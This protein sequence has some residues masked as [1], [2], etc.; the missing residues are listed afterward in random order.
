ARMKFPA[1]DRSRP[2]AGLKI[3]SDDGEPDQ[4]R[5]GRRMR[6]REIIALASQE[7][8]MSHATPLLSATLRTIRSA[9]LAAALLAVALPASGAGKTFRFANSTE[10]LTMDPHGALV[11]L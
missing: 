3:F 10:L 5:R 7:I 6:P 1:E 9:T 11:V 4:A 2:G 8:V